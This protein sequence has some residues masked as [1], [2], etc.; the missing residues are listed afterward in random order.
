MTLAEGCSGTPQDIVDPPSGGYKICIYSGTTN[1]A[2]EYPSSHTILYSYFCLYNFNITFIVIYTDKICTTVS[3]PACSDST[4]TVTECQT[5]G[6]N[7]GPVESFEKENP[8]VYGD[9]CKE[10]GAVCLKTDIQ[11]S[12]CSEAKTS[13]FLDVQCGNVKKKYLHPYSGRWK[14]L[15]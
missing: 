3:V 7:N 4:T 9:E 14:N 13:E 1:L 2:I 5:V 6:S 8:Q 10:N 12:T 15:C 11:Y